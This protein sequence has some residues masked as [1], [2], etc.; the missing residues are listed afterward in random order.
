[1]DL[2][3]ADLQIDTVEDHLV[4]VFKFD[5]QVIDFKHDFFPYGLSADR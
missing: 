1:M 4:L 3:R 2:A 5:V